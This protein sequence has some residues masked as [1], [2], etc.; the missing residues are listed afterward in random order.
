MNLVLVGLVVFFL[1][2]VSVLVVIWLYLGTSKQ[3]TQ[4]TTPSE[5]PPIQKVSPT[6][7]KVWK[8]NG[9]T[10]L[11][12]GGGG[13]SSSMI[14]KEN[15]YVTELNGGSGSIID[16]IGVKCSNGVSLGPRGG[17]G[18]TSFAIGNKDG[19]DKL[20]TRSGALVDSIWV[21]DGGKELGK[22]G[23]DGGDVPTVL[24]CNG[25]KIMGLNV[26]TGG[27]VDNIQVVCGTQ[28]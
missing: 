13:E 12:G 27:S 8:V 2:S 26:R 6:H 18:G 11:V 4:T 17:S 15:S 14:C 1:I 5:S 7:P 3:S 20:I 9:L 16:R 24:A 21:Y 10:Q 23:G 19:F 22:F 25:G 28:Q